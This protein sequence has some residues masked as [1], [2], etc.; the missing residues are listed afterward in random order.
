[1]GRGCTATKKRTGSLVYLY[2]YIWES[3]NR[4][5]Y[6]EREREALGIGHWIVEIEI[7]VCESE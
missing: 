2:I 7:D 5:V 3:V 4:T 1:M 6:R